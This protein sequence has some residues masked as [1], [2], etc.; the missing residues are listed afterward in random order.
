LRPPPF[1]P[2]RPSCER[3][4]AL[5]PCA[6]RFFFVFGCVIRTVAMVQKVNRNR[7]FATFTIRERVALC[8]G[9]LRALRD[10]WGRMALPCCRRSDLL[11]R[12]RGPLLHSPRRETGGRGQARPTPVRCRKRPTVP[13]GLSM[14]RWEHGTVSG[15]NSG[16]RCCDCRAAIAAYRRERRAGGAHRVRLPEAVDLETVEPN[17]PRPEL[18][19]SPVFPPATRRPVAPRRPLAVATRQLE[20]PRPAPHFG[21]PESSP[22]D[23]D[24]LALRRYLAGIGPSPSLL[25]LREATA[26]RR[27]F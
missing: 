8:R 12:L 18:S 13:E 10:L 4:E 22:L 19:P 6:P 3:R 23:A 25:A 20:S 14:A 2:A 7:D 21:F 11:P 17:P 27:P 9:H 16:C 15:Y 1:E 26:R 5:E 24:V